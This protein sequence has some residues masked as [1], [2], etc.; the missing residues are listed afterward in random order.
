MH[1]AV[2]HNCV[3]LCFYFTAAA[4]LFFVVFP[5]LFCFVYF[6]ALFG[7]RSIFLFLSFSCV[8][9]WIN[10]AFAHSLA[11]GECTSQDP[12]FTLIFQWLLRILFA[13]PS[14]RGWG[15]AVQ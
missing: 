1:I 9:V 5:F 7:Q 6:S 11:A 4:S 13:L 2:R 15:D 8:C 3:S 14:T 10:D 12:L